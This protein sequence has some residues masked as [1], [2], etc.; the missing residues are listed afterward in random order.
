M[1]ENLKLI[2]LSIMCGILVLRASKL[3]FRLFHFFDN[4][5]VC[6]GFH[7]DNTMSVVFLLQINQVLFE[8]DYHYF[9]VLHI[10]VMSMPRRHSCWSSIQFLRLTLFM[11]IELTGP[12]AHAY[13]IRKPNM[14]YVKSQTF[15]I[16]PTFIRFTHCFKR[17][18]RPK[19][20][21]YI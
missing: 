5:I 16:L 8:I 11:L 12:K 15:L 19:T 4:K 20:K 13:F 9:I 18:Q 10:C 6:L 7:V 3:G 21:L 2:C 14:V 17:Q 1:S